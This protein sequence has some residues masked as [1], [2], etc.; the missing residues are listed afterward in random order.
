MKLSSREKELV[1]S[2]FYELT[3][4]DKLKNSYIKLMTTY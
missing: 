1:N 4:E 2:K 3:E